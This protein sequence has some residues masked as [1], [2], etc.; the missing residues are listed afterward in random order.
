[1]NPIAMIL[2][3]FALSFVFVVVLYLYEAYKRKRYVQR[4]QDDQR[5]FN[6]IRE[7]VWWRK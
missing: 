5:K 1:M 3:S 6:P 7:K 4:K 2:L